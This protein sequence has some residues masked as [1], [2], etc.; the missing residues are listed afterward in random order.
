MTD[1]PDKTVLITGCSSG[2]GE[3]L[4]KG[5]HRRP[6]YRVLATAR[7]DKDVESL[8]AAGLTALPLDL[9]DSRSVSAAADEAQALGGGHVDILVNNGAYGQPGAVE[10]LSREALRAQFEVNV[11]G[12][13]ELTTR[14][15]PGMR[16]Q[17]WG[18]IIQISSI[19][20]LVSLP[21]RGAYNASKH[22]LEALSD[23]L[24]LELRGTGIH[25]S[26]IEPGPIESRFRHNAMRRFEEHV[27]V[28]DSPH[29]QRYETVRARLHSD[30]PD[31]FTLPPEAVLSK[32][33][34]A[35]ERRSPRPRYP[36]TVPAHALARLK[37][38]LPD[39]LFD[40][41][42]GRLSR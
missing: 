37:R 25:V 2:I 6:G 36:V 7:R 3:C 27:R 42:V 32:A 15:L 34:L 31:P 23:T 26:L 12:T 41:L 17:G 13:H 5:I 10:D 33:L 1:Q 39:R 8:R 11:L 18:R 4:A 38:V 29:R 40:A 20:G 16:R 35:M 21:F 19:L 28:A 24:R 9:A 30:T 22:A 14:V